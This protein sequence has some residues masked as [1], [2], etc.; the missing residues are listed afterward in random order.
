MGNTLPSVFSPIDITEPITEDRIRV[1]CQRDSPLDKA[2][3]G[4]EIKKLVRDFNALGADISL[5]DGKG[6][7]KPDDE[8]CSDVQKMIDVNPSKVCMMKKGEKFDKSKL[9][10]MVNSINQRF[11][12]NILI[13]KNGD[14]RAGLRPVHEICDDAYMIS[15]L[16]KRRINDDRKYVKEGLVKKIEDL[17]TERDLL[18]VHFQELI[19]DKQDTMMFDDARTFVERMGEQKSQFDLMFGRKIDF[20]EKS[21]LNLGDVVIERVD[22]SLV[23]VENLKKEMDK[24]RGFFGASKPEYAIDALGA[25]ALNLGGLAHEAKS[26]LKKIGHDDSEIETIIHS[27]GT[28]DFNDEAYQKLIAEIGDKKFKTSDPNEIAHLE[29]CSLIFSKDK[30]DLQREL[31]GAVVTK[32]LIEGVKD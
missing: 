16:I 6:V 8:L 3:Q 22:P 17:K 5:R 13:F 12:S 11:G 9:I 18:D 19:A 20:L 31:A 24:H 1:A 26:C 14:E 29:K 10:A 23:K 27:I 7:P 28:D 30:P 32:G 2:L 21:A 15:G 4:F 25:I